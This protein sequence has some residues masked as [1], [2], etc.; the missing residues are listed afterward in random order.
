M[1]FFSKINMILIATFWLQRFSY[2]KMFCNQTQNY[3]HFDKHFQA[4]NKRKHIVW[5][6][7]KA[8]FLQYKHPQILT[9][10]Y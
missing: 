3:T 1:S 2:I 9:A 5:Y 10:F 8:L 7:Q 4:E 6:R